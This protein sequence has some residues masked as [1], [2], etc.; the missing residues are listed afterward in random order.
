M[1]DI[2]ELIEFYRNDIKAKAPYGSQNIIFDT[3]EMYNSLKYSK[4]EIYKYLT[5][6]YCLQEYINEHQHL[7]DLAI[8]YSSNSDVKLS[9]STC[10]NHWYKKLDEQISSTSLEAGEMPDAFNLVSQ[11]FVSKLSEYSESYVDYISKAN[12]ARSTKA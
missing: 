7:G 3:A 6:Q 9:L 12:A 4:P 8:C 5:P 1:V 10:F 2:G 11:N